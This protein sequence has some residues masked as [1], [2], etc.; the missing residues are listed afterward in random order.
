MNTMPHRAHRTISHGSRRESTLRS[1]SPHSGQGRDIARKDWLAADMDEMFEE[2]RFY[3][4]KRP[5]AFP[6]AP[7]VGEASRELLQCSRGME[8]SGLWLC[9]RSTKKSGM[10]TSSAKCPDS[11]H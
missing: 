10:R 8:L 7:Q 3:H 5:P 11:L 4:A 6:A 1:D 9:R 2:P